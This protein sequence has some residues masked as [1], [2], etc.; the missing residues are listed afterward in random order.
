MFREDDGV[1][2]AKRQSCVWKLKPGLRGVLAAKRD[3]EIEFSIAMAT[4]HEVVIFN[5]QSGELNN[6]AFRVL[7]FIA[8]Q[9][10]QSDLR[11][12]GVGTVNGLAVVSEGFL[13]KPLWVAARLR[14]LRPSVAVRVQR[15]ALDTQS[16]AS[17]LEFRGAVATANGL[18]V[19]K[20]R[21]ICRQPA[22]NSRDFIG[23]MHHSQTAGLLSVV[24]DGLVGLVNVLRCEVGNVSLRAAEMPAHFVEAAPL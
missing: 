6:A 21:T 5:S 11:F 2:E 17:L 24:G 3:C 9:R 7:L 15:H 1:S 23:E 19:G 13:C 16:N 8:F 22:Q 14:S 10:R 18:Q 20:Q 12:A 4:T